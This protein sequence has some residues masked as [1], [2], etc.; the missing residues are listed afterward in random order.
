MRVTVK[1]DK[2]IKIIKRH[3]TYYTEKQIADIIETDG[4]EYFNSAGSD[5]DIEYLGFGEWKIT[6]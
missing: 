2:L 3:F 5:L 1:K 6:I 4:A